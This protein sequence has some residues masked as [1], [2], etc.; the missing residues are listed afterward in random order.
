MVGRT[1]SDTVLPPLP[2]ATAA[3]AAMTRDGLQE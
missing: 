2:A 3:P 1:M